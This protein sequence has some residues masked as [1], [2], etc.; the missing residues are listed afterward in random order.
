MLSAFGHP[1]AM[2]RR[3][4]CCWLKFDYFQTWANNT[5]HAATQRNT[6]SKRTQH[7]APRVVAICCVGTLRSFC[8]GHYVVTFVVRTTWHN[9]EYGRDLF[10]APN[11]KVGDTKCF[12]FFTLYNLTWVLESKNPFSWIFHAVFREKIS[13]TSITCIW[14]QDRRAFP[15]CRSLI[16]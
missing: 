3:V 7:F 1:V 8:R 15:P 14:R 12:L 4:G 6:V 10:L 5:Q 13:P 9:L 11:E 2:L 16:S